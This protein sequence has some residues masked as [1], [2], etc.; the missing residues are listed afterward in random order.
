[1]SPYIIAGSESLQINS[2]LVI[3]AISV[4]GLFAT[5]LI[6]ETLGLRLS[7]TIK[8]EEKNN[9]LRTSDNGSNF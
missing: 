7:D 1:M 8:E 6:K 2:Y 5:L 4:A 9:I 3:G